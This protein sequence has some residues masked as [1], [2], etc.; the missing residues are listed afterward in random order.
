VA[1]KGV[2]FR[3]GGNYDEFLEYVTA[4]VDSSALASLAV[5]NQE[6]K[7]LKSIKERNKEFLMNLFNQ[8][9]VS[10]PKRGNA[11]TQRE[12]FEK[13]ADQV[14]EGDLSKFKSP[15]RN[16]PINFHPFKVFKEKQGRDYSGD[17]VR[18]FL[19]ETS[20]AR[21]KELVEFTP[22]DKHM[23][24]N[25]TE[26]DLNNVSKLNKE[27]LL[28][29]LSPA[30]REELQDMS[31]QGIMK[32][33]RGERNLGRLSKEDLLALYAEE[34]KYDLVKDRRDRPFRISV[35][36]SVLDSKKEDF[37]ESTLR[38]I[39]AS[40]S[41]GRLRQ[42]IDADRQQKIT[43]TTQE[44]FLKKLD[45]RISEAEAKPVTDIAS[46]RILKKHV[47]DLKKASARKDWKVDTFTVNHYVERINK[48]LDDKI[49]PKPLFANKD[50]QEIKEILTLKGVPEAQYSKLSNEDLYDFAKNVH[51][52][53]V[54]EYEAKTKEEKAY[55]LAKLGLVGAPRKDVLSVARLNLNK[56][57]DVLDTNLKRLS[58]EAVIKTP[59]IKPVI[60]EDL[61]GTQ[62]KAEKV[63]G[64]EI[65]NEAINKKLKEIRDSKPW[66]RKLERP[67]LRK[68]AIRRIVAEKKGW[69]VVDD[70]IER[71]IGQKI[72]ADS[73]GFT[74]PLTKT[75]YEKDLPE[76]VT[77]IPKRPS[78]FR[79][80]LQDE[81]KETVDPKTGVVRKERTGTP[82]STDLWKRY[83]DYVEKTELPAYEN[84][85]RET[86]ELRKLGEE[87]PVRA[88]FEYQ[89][90]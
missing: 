58:K 82:I 21:K 26:S 3:G 69:P 67:E 83:R 42:V 39:W 2:N 37:D 75:P 17:R 62:V 41:F 31:K 25:L 57:D 84:Y 22:S 89:M 55:R 18:E 40:P 38:S 80:H 71:R 9:S 56:D 70:E 19:D 5:E 59:K 72:E 61:P 30:T 33:L 51:G 46:V 52:I 65:S 10:K 63:I 20:E 6:D 79:F 78:F 34:N 44:G 47:D 66:L 88:F 43:D 50:P 23:V 48:L 49:K 36:G 64:E 11:D 90:D 8:R 53:G 76:I 77:E 45:N 28:S 1:V 60:L 16:D 24:D 81:M 68:M 85:M 7:D 12:N 14:S 4:T 54:R 27:Q 35:R 73:P 74:H 15:H 29:I 13:L 87:E 86:R 32:S